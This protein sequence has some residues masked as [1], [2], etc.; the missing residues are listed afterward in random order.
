MPYKN[1]YDDV[2]AVEAAPVAAKRQRMP[3]PDWMT[4]SF[5]YHGSSFSV[6]VDPYELR[7]SSKSLMQTL[8]DAAME[9]KYRLERTI[10]IAKAKL[11]NLDAFMSS[12]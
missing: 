6:H 12:L 1:N 4:V 10:N 11:D 8:N 3:R 2:I 5:N 9:Q 7:H